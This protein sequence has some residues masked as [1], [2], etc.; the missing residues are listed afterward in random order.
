[1]MHGTDQ[2]TYI[3]VHNFLYAQKVVGNKLRT[4]L[5]LPTHPRNKAITIIYIQQVHTGIRVLA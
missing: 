4:R 3:N 2:T 1:M 5:K